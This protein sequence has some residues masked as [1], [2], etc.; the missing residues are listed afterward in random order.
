MNKKNFGLVLMFLWLL[1]CFALAGEKE[2]FYPLENIR[3]GQVAEGYTDLGHGREKFQVE[4]VGFMPHFIDENKKIILAHMKGDLKKYSIIAGMSGSPVFIDG[5][6]VGALAFGFGNFADPS[7]CGITPIGYMTDDPNYR[8]DLKKMEIGGIEKTAA[9]LPGTSINVALV[10]GDVNI[11]ANGTAT[12]INRQG[13]IFAFGHPL[14]SR[15]S[16]WRKT[17]PMSGGVIRVGVDSQSDYRE[18]R[19]NRFGLDM[20]PLPKSLQLSKTDADLN[21][22]VKIAI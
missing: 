22:R 11:T 10:E 5:K 8:F 2:N 21:R 3:I 7:T 6:L 1:S 12:Y 16:A 13:D 9:I 14:F 20:I 17:H 18:F 4:I 19:R 15:F